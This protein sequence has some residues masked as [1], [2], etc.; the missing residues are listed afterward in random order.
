MGWTRIASY[1]LQRGPFDRFVPGAAVSLLRMIH[2]TIIIYEIS[3]H[4]HLLGLAHK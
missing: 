1:I 2:F 3:L 4:H